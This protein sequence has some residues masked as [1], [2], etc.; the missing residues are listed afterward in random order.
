MLEVLH[1]FYGYPKKDE[2]IHALGT[3]VKSAG[4]VGACTSLVR[5]LCFVTPALCLRQYVKSVHKPVKG[6]QDN[7]IHTWYAPNHLNI[8][9]LGST[10]MRQQFNAWVEAQK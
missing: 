1:K 9:P 8:K 2:S 10:A 7:H 4:W 6:C 5:S 3:K